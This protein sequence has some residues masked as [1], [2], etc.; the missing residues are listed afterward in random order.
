MKTIS[1]SVGEH[2]QA[3][4]VE[5]VTQIQDVLILLKP[6]AVVIA[7]KHEEFE[8]KDIKTEAE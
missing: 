2:R 7:Q 8:L 1:V 6:A 4:I 5:L 3:V